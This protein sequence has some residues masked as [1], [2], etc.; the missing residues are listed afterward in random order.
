MLND[1]NKIFVMSHEIEQFLQ[2]ETNIVLEFDCNNRFDV[3]EVWDL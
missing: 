3:K 2:Y 1:L